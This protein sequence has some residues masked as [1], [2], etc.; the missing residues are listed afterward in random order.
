MS[1]KVGKGGRIV[2]PPSVCQKYGVRVGSRLIV[3]ELPGRICLV[4]IKT[5]E[6][7]TQAIYGSI[8]VDNPLDNP[9]SLARDHMRQQ[10]QKR[11][12]IWSINFQNYCVVKALVK[13]QILSLT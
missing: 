9:K 6:K 12:E 2:L 4:P 3:A 8:K 10:L 11:L 13:S 7:P 1:I 5:Y